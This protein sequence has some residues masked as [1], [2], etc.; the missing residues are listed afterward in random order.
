[1]PLG[2]DATIR[3]GRNV[4]GT[5]PLKQSDIESD[6]PYNTRKRLGLPP[7]PIANPGLASMR[8]AAR[9]RPGRLPL[10]R[11]QARRRRTTSSRRASRSSARS[12]SSTAT[13]AADP[14]PHEISATTTLVGLLRWPGRHSLSPRM[15]NAAFA[16][17]GLDW[18]YVPLPTPP[19]RLGEAVR[20]LAALGFVG[21]NVTT[22]HKHG[23]DGALR[24]GRAVREHA[25]R[26]RR[27]G[28]GLV[29]GRGDPRR[30]RRR[31]P[32]RAR[33]RR[34]R[35]GVH[36]G[37]PERAPVRAARNVAARR[38]GRRPRRQRDVRARRRARRARLRPDARR[39]A[40]PGDGHG[41]GRSPGGG[42]VVT[43]LEVLLAQ[44]A[45][46]FELWTG[47][48]HRSRS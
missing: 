30:P 15:H 46:A 9:S 25:R 29:D 18:A 33:R 32:G 27:T 1:M 14:V 12:R 26:P 45:A 20:G 40:V 3:Y 23:R 48:P 6:N 21:A 43:G 37:A 19:E 4:P 28:R 2:I 31:E 22:P 39:P 10:L 36:A 7:T 44:G 11:A 13:A 38:G 42:D 47:V 24:D 8:A 16:A 41:R 5:E 35:D 34:R 17:L